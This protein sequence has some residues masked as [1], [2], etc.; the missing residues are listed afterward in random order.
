MLARLAS[1]FVSGGYHE[2]T[3]SGPI[4]TVTASMKTVQDWKEGEL[5]V[6]VMQ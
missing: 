5:F 4:F 1:L 6:R 2:R 3:L